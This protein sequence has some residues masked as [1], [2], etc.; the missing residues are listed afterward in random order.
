MFARSA[1]GT[2]SR[3]EPPLDI[4]D[5]HTHFYDPS[6]PEGVPWPG[7]GT[8]LFRTV[9]PK[10]LRALEQYRPVTGTVIVEASAWLEDNHWL[11]DLA[12][13]DP[14]I[15]GV[16]G[17]IKPAEPSFAAN[18]KRFAANPLFRGIRISGAMASA[19][20][21]RNEFDDLRLLSELDLQ[22]D[23]NGGPETPA[24]VARIAQRVPSLR[25]VLNHMGNVEINAQSPAQIWQ[26]GILQAADQPN[27]FCKI[28]AFMENAARTGGAA[29]TDPAFYQ[30]YL[31][32]VWNAFGDDR[33]IY[34]SNWPV[35]ERASDYAQQQRISLEY[36]LMRGGMEVARKFCASNAKRAYK[37]V[38]RP[39]R[40][41]LTAKT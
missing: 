35:S 38:E 14:F 29:S 36:A 30:P 17:N 10:N 34:G 16:V 11:L 33:V 4:I 19:L 23:I 39:G 25:V 41:D 28:S 12:K 40:S 22:L 1:S 26:Q 21:E 7:K 18:I 6:R 37:W 3:E 24:I 20:L 13:D 9:L 15:V 2:S 27:T 5:C 31:D 32:V 8:P